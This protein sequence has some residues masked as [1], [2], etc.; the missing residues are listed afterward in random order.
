MIRS[1]YHQDMQ[2]TPVIDYLRCITMRLPPLAD[3][4]K[5]SMA[6]QLFN[7]HRKVL[8]NCLLQHMLNASEVLAERQTWASVRCTGS[9]VNFS[10]LPYPRRHPKL[11]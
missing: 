6:S 5:P 8:L 7:W 10:E 2:V 9:A 4:R 3:T 1:T 11:R